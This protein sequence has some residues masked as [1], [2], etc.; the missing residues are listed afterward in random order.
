MTVFKTFLKIL[1]KNKGIVILYTV[2]LLVFAGINMKSNNNVA[3]FE[4]SRPDILKKTVIRQQLQTMKMQEMMHYFTKMQI[5]FYIF[6]KT[7]IMI[8]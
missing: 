6:Q 7:I 5:T 4:A 1:N 2:I 8:L 3:T